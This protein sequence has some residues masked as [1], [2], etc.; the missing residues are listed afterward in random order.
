MA[1]HRKPRNARRK[2]GRRV[3]LAGVAVLGLV[4]GATAGGIALKGSPARPAVAATLDS[5][6]VTSAMVNSFARAVP[7]AANRTVIVY[8]CLGSGKI[9][10]ISTSSAK[11]PANSVRVHWVAQ[12]GPASSPS[13][14]P[15]QS[16]SSRPASSPRPSPSARPSRVPSPLP[17]PSSSSSPSPLP[18]PLS[19]SSPSPKTSP[20][21]VPVKSSP[22]PTTP[23]VGLANCTMNQNGGANDTVTQLDGNTYHLQA[24]EYNSGAN[25]KICTNGSPDFTISSSGV[26]V[27][28]DGA[29]G[30]YPSLYKGCHWGDCT[31]N[32]GMPV[33]VST[34]SNTPG[35]VTTTYSTKTVSSGAWDDSYDIWFNP[36]QSTSNNS[37]GLEMM[38]WLNHFGGVQPA[39]SPGPTVN[40]D[41]ISFRVWYGGSGNGGTVSFVANS[42]TSS[43]T[44]MD[45][46]PLAAYAVSRGYM[47]NSWFLIDVEAGFEPWTSG[48][49]LTADAFNVTGH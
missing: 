18:R 16:S 7:D 28:H 25:F 4:A 10:G 19:S 41:G 2:S 33:A 43:V 35:K 29:P 13:P 42:P 5:A 34:M 48:Q 32:S 11:C 9:S 8:A 22:A 17:R 40:I 20:V 30:A 24:N 39:G 49:G 36:A 31:A 46:G 45:L 44:N 14:L 15:S 47:Q 38:I 21:P 37:S 27:S 12:S 1:S 23:P 26:S 6:W 3:S